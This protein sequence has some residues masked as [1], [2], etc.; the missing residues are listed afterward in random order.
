MDALYSKAKELGGNV[1]GEHGIGF[2]K[3]GDLVHQHQ[4]D[5]AVLRLM[6]DIKSMFDPQNILNPGKV[7]D[8]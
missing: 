7:V 6:K 4:T 8:L 5:P 2:L 3:K 1:S